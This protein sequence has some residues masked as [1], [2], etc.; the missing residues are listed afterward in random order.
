MPDAEGLK[1][2]IQSAQGEYSTVPDNDSPEHGYGIR[3]LTFFKVCV[4]LMIQ[5]RGTLLFG[6]SFALEELDTSPEY[7]SQ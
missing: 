5:F 6:C 2:Y 4:R 1:P 7:V 3:Y